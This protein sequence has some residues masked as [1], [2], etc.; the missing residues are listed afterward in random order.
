MH[1]VANINLA[2][3]RRSSGGV[4]CE[5]KWWRLEK[6]ARDKQPTDFCVCQ[7]KIAKLL[8]MGI[9]STWQNF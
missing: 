9:F 6:N 1:E 8:E 2:T 5:E 3:Q 4:T 7:V